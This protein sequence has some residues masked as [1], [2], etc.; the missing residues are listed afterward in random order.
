LIQVFLEDRPII[1]LDEWA[2]DQDPAFRRTFYEEILPELKQAGKTLIVISHDDQ[3]FHVADRV[4]EM[5]DGRI[6]E[7][8]LSVDASIKFR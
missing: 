6:L 7:Q 2:A 3:Y 4:I 8:R 5:H 1:V